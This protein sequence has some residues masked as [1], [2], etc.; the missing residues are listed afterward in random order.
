MVALNSS[1]FF[2]NR[3]SRAR[4]IASICTDSLRFKSLDRTEMRLWIY[5]NC[6]GLESF[7][8]DPIGFEGSEWN[9]YEYVNSKPFRLVDPSGLEA[10]DTNTGVDPSK[11][12]PVGNTCLTTIWYPVNNLEQCLDSCQHRRQCCR[13]RA[14]F[15]CTWLG[16]RYCKSGEKGQQCRDS[17]MQGCL[18]VYLPSC[19]DSGCEDWCRK[20]FPCK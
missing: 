18:L 7:S 12:N 8:R 3:H 10:M 17:F 14:T 1:T 11:A 2:E 4:S 15:M 6:I 19:I 20:K 9:L 5:E 13:N 16:I